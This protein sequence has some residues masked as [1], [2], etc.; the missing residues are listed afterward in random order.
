MKRQW[1]RDLALAFEE[2]V[3]VE[4]PDFSK[5]DSTRDP[6][7]NGILY[8]KDLESR[9]ITI[10]FTLEMSPK[11]AGFTFE[12][13]WSS[14]SKF[15]GLLPPMD[16]EESKGEPDGRFRIGIVMPDVKSLDHWWWIRTDSEVNDV[17][18][19]GLETLKVR[20]VP[21]LER[22]GEDKPR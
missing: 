12:G 11:R 16:P 3:S 4:F 18:D 8:Y 14:D 21:L 13:A 2:A 9:D 7:G 6:Y 22:I 19:R 5:A 15:P 1:K 10:F 17:L 20:L